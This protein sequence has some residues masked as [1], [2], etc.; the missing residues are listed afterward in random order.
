MPIGIHLLVDCR[1][2]PRDVCLA[3][4]VILESLATGARLA[5]ATVLSQVRYH[6]GHNSPPGFAAAI[7]LDESHCSAHSYADLGMVALDFFTCGDTDPMRILEYLQTQ[8]DLGDV[9][10]RRV[11][12]FGEPATMAGPAPEALVPMT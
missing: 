7:L 3:D 11:E 1:N 12:R 8:V 2:V 4:G 5:G 9:T 6:F 10:V